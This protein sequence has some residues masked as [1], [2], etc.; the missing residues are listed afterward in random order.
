MRVGH[1]VEAVRGLP[2]QHLLLVAGREHHSELLAFK[3]RAGQGA[4]EPDLHVTVLV[5]E[6]T[7]GELS[8]NGQVADL[9]TDV[10]E[11]RRGKAQLHRL[12]FL[13]RNDDAHL[14]QLLQ[15]QVL[16]VEL[17]PFKLE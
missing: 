7:Q 1:L 3:L 2:R 8:G 13:R 11:F 10:V 6:G 15:V 16:R 5:T 4:F 9:Q 12:Q 17:D 14:L